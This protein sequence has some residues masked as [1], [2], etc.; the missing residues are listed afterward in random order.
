[1]LQIER[2]VYGSRGEVVEQL[3]FPV[4][5]SA[6]IVRASITHE[7]RPIK[8]GISSNKPGTS[9]F[10]LHT[11]IRHIVWA[12]E[13]DGTEIFVINETIFG[14]RNALG[15]ITTRWD[16]CYTPTPYENDFSHAPRQ[17]HIRANSQ[18]E[19]FSQGYRIL[20]CALQRMSSSNIITT[21]ARCASATHE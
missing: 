15:I 9:S 4:M 19:N 21:I 17:W 20:M 1:M 7:A 6:I 16:S 2:I 10:T 5:T 8:A 18:A 3:T 14:H 12:D 13:L 11:D